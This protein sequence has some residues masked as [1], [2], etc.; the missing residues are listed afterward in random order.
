[1][2]YCSVSFA[3][4]C[5]SII[6]TESGVLNIKDSA[7]SSIPATKSSFVSLYPGLWH[8]VPYKETPKITTD[9]R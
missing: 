4:S 2:L 3:R 9:I 5:S 8:D 6:L 7:L 1:M